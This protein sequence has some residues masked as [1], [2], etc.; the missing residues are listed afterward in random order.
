MPNAIPAQRTDAPHRSA[1]RISWD[2]LRVVAIASVLLHHATVTSFDS[3]PELGAPPFGFQLS[4]GAGALMVISAYFACATLDKGRPA[5][6]LRSR[7][8]RLLPAYMF[9]VLL[10]YAVQLWVAPVG[11][12]QLDL[13]DL[14]YNLLLVPGWFP[15]VDLVDF[16]YWTVPLQVMAFTA[17]ALLYRRVSGTSLRVLLWALIVGPLLLRPLLDQ[18][19][20][21]LTIY[22]G[23]VLHR[24]QLFAAGIAIWLWSKGRLG[25]GHLAALITAALLA[26]AIHSS[27]PGSTI[28]LGVLL[29]A[30]C[31]AAAG[32]DW[33][34]LRV[35]ARPINWLAGISYGVYLVH[36]QIGTIVMN[37]IASLGGGP[38]TLLAGFLTSAVVLGWL[39][40]A[41]VERPAYRWLTAASRGPV[42][43]RLV[44][45][46][47][48]Y[49]FRLVG[50][51][52]QSQLGSLGTLP[53]SRE[54]S[55]RP[56][57]QPIMSAAAPLTVAELSVPPVL[58]SQL[59]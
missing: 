46:V 3:H 23:F 9:A 42:L 25:N 21:L 47:R 28:G 29:V 8:A 51:I 57:S 27:E 16:A 35:L 58:S 10:T 7:L 31:A 12:S 43:V 50:G 18:S 52:S 2:L 55:W 49:S 14:V 32:P 44:L 41:V 4:M 56:V 24:A 13:R 34:P 37:R 33:R 17:G 39:L 15:D 40:T 5:R 6:F 59:R 30:V 1:R 19:A 38:W 22:N 20:T 36:Q 26:Q 54:P 45:A 53:L 48:L 11:F